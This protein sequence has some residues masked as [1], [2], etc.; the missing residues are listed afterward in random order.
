MAML[1]R[2]RR[3]SP[4]RSY[5]QRA[6]LGLRF[7][8]APAWAA[9]A[10]IGPDVSKRRACVSGKS[11]VLLSA[12]SNRAASS[13]AARE[14]WVNER[15]VATYFSVSTRTVRRWRRAGMPSRLFNGARRYRISE[16]ER[17]HQGGTA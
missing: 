17:W 10:S 7:R 8:P 15:A 6:I 11:A 5:H 2:H 13:G 14:A 4:A 9:P 1:N 12:E 16:V 3:G